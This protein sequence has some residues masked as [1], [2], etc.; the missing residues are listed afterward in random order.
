MS[1]DALAFQQ[2][3]EGFGFRDVKVEP[4]PPPQHVRDWAAEDDE[5]EE[6][7]LDD[8]MNELTYLRVTTSQGTFGIMLAAYPALDLTGTGV[9]YKDLV[10]D[11]EGVPDGFSFIGF[12]EEEDIVKFRQLLEARNDSGGT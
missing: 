6:G 2:I 10:P 4:I 1:D 3:L 8:V 7:E 9:T 11:A 12:G 5:D